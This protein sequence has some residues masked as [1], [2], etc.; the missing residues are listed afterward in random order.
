MVK[1]LD[2]A[3]T[4]L[5]ERK[6]L[7]EQLDEIRDYAQTLDPGAR[8]GILQAV[9]DLLSEVRQGRDPGREA[10]P[11]QGDDRGVTR[12]RVDEDTPRETFNVNRDLPKHALEFNG[13][14]S[15]IIKVS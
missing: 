12:A 8:Q 15:P 9:A 14:Q 11:S 3:E 2:L 6:D 10:A 4:P 13:L 7:D 1:S 5:N